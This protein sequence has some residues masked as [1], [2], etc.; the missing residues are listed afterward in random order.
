MDML[1][2]STLI[3]VQLI[4]YWENTWKAYRYKEIFDN[5]ELIRNKFKCELKSPI[6]MGRI[7][8]YA[9]LLYTL[10]GV[11]LI[12][13]FFIILIRYVKSLNGFR[14]ILLQYGDTILK[15]KLIEFTIFAGI[16]MAFQ[17]EL[18]NYLLRYMNE[19][20][21]SQIYE[22]P[23]KEKLFERFYILQDIHNILMVNI[24]HIEDYS[25]WSLPA[26]MLKMFFEF[27]I[28]AY[29]IYFSL[30]YKIPAVFQ[31]C[32]FVLL[33]IEF[34]RLMCLVIVICVYCRW[35]LRN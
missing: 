6:D 32:M 22:W 27:T 3:I 30:D 24:R 33:H 4:V 31:S 19:I 17:M 1:S 8:L 29:W 18:N 5:F 20:R 13:V 14:L 28:T 10:L 34:F 7:R 21:K 11:Y 12:I 35:I 2:Y 26:L 15:L 16:V 23:A 9:M 25:C